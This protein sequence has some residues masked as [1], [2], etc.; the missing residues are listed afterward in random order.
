M[1]FKKIHLLSELNNVLNKRKE[2]KAWMTHGRTILCSRDVENYQNGRV[3]STRASCDLGSRS[4]LCMRAE[5]WL[6][7]I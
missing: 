3:V 2:L 1:L 6:M 5:T 7:S 4:E